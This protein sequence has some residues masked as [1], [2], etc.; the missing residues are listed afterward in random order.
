MGSIIRSSRGDSGS[1]DYSPYEEYIQI[2]VMK[3]VFEGQVALDFPCRL[4][5]SAQG[6]VH[7]RS[8]VVNLRKISKMPRGQ[9][10]V[11]TSDLYA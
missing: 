11:I 9:Q 7:S 1:L 3:T 2:S 4:R 10:S 8:L 6:I 5:R